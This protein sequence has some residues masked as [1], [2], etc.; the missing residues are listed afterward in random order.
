[1][2]Y[3]KF[4]FT[5]LNYNN[6]MAF[7][8]RCYCIRGITLKHDARIPFTWLVK[9]SCRKRSGSYSLLERVVG[10]D[11]APPRRFICVP[12]DLFNNTNKFTEKNVRT[13]KSSKCNTIWNPMTYLGSDLFCSIST[14]RKIVSR[15]V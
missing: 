15:L 2:L 10:G 1:M 11:C 9:T 7:V 4:M 5:S 8:V 6:G 14:T 12:C 3:S 13:M